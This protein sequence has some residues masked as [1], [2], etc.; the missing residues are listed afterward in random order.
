V[1]ET[2]SRKHCLLTHCL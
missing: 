1:F 2:V